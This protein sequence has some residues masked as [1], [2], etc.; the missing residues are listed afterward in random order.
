MELGPRSEGISETGSE[1][2]T[3]KK[4]ESICAQGDVLIRRIDTIPAGAKAM[5]PVD[6]RIV[7]AHSETGHDHTIALD[8]PTKRHKPNVEMFSGDNPLVAWIKVNRPSVLEHKRTFDTHE[9]IEF[10]PGI[11]EIRR[12]REYSPEGWRRVAD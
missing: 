11:Y 7:I 8:R 1:D 4:F 12:Q 9:S 5:A 6:G 3:M 2:L 10:S